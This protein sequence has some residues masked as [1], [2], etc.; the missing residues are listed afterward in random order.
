MTT[1]QVKKTSYVYL[2]CYILIPLAAA[3]AGVYIGW[4]YF[5]A[6]G[7]G[8]V[9]CFVVVPGAAILWW[10]FGGSALYKLGKRRMLKRLDGMGV[11]RRQIFYSDSCV[12]SV[13]MEQG[14]IGLLFFWNPLQVQ[15]LPASR[16][17]RAWAD[18]GAGGAGF[19]R[20]TSRVSFLFELDGVRIRVNTFTSNQRWKLNDEKVLEGISKAD[21]WVQVLEQA[22]EVQYGTV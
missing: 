5:R 11:D 8:A 15:V 9:I 20:G 13:D 2:L 3:A 14:K 21:L 6:G 7:A 22:R 17:T 19:M 16:V 18:E 12:V 1:D 10:I 4:R